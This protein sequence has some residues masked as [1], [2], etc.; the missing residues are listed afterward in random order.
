MYFGGTSH[1]P[2]CTLLFVRRPF[3]FTK[4]KPGGLGIFW[5]VICRT[6]NRKRNL[7][8]LLHMM[9][10]KMPHL[11]FS[12]CYVQQYQYMNVCVFSIFIEWQEGSLE[13]QKGLQDCSKILMKHWKFWGYPMRAGVEV[14]LLLIVTLPSVL[15]PEIVHLLVSV[16]LKESKQNIP[17]TLVFLSVD[18]G[19]PVNQKAI[20]NLL[21]AHP[22]IIV[23]PSVIRAKSSSN[24]QIHL[25]RIVKFVNLRRAALHPP[26]FE[27]ALP[28]STK[29]LLTHFA[30]HPIHLGIEGQEEK[31]RQ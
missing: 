2:W 14:A 15:H 1:L 23:V 28:P 3:G 16:H 21:N 17:F 8:S 25:A 7:C 4:N 11:V 24:H 13:N 20:H 12:T 19:H 10:C 18:P 29:P 31:H 6:R 30:V 5:K 9:L 26:L 27:T 22:T